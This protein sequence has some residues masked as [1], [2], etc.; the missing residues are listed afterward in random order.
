MIDRGCLFYDAIKTCSS[1]EGGGSKLKVKRLI[2]VCHGPNK[3]N[4]LLATL[5]HKARNSS[6]FDAVI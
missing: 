1:E 4:E 6:E 2:F 5:L 3:Q